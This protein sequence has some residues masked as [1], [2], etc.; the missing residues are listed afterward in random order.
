MEHRNRAIAGLMVNAFGA[1]G[2]GVPETRDIPARAR[3]PVD[4]EACKHRQEPDG[5]HCY[6]FKEKPGPY[7]AQFKAADPNAPARHLAMAEQYR[8]ERHRRKAEAFAARQ[9]K[10][11]GKE[12]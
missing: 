4:C 3:T 8:I 2:G 12:V 7:C 9:S 5:G 11:R 10:E 1:F 6:M